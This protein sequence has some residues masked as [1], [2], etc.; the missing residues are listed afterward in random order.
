[1]CRCHLVVVKVQNRR[2]V[3]V[4]L[5]MVIFCCVLCVPLFFVLGKARAVV[6]SNN[7]TNHVVYRPEG[8][9]CDP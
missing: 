4:F 3:M 7:M 2:M 9:E 5:E 8:M 6:R 1:M